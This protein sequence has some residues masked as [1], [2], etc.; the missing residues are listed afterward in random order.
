MNKIT[1]DTDFAASGGPL[2]RPTT[3]AA[4]G[5]PRLRWSL[6]EFERLGELGIFSEHEH[7]E[8]IDG[9]LVPMAAKGNR[10]ERVRGK[11]LNF[12][13]RRLP[14]ALEI[15]SELGW[16]PGGDFY[17]EPEIFICP[18]TSE[19]SLVP[20]GEVALLIEVAHTS[21]AYDTGLKMRT[22]AALGVRE[23]WVVNAV[24]LETGVHR[25]PG[26]GGY[27]EVRDFAPSETI[28]PHLVPALALAMA[29]LGIE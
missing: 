21:L 16:R 13:M 10:H 26:D 28:V 12:L 9:E 22:Y 11:L 15:Y 18:P 20:P 25:K 5:V 29:D 7:V 19:P 1:R 23:Y 8:L 27:A 3:Q 24:T 17:C 4:E 6:A 14:T 2:Q